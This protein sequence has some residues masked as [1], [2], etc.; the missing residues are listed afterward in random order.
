M[1]ILLRQTNPPETFT[2]VANKA[3]PLTNI[4]LDNNFVELLNVING[5]ISSQS[6]LFAF[7]TL[8]ENYFAYIDDDR[9]IGFYSTDTYN[10]VRKSIHNLRLTRADGLLYDGSEIVNKSFLI[11]EGYLKSTG[12]FVNGPLFSLDNFQI[13]KK[14]NAGIEY[15]CYAKINY[16]S[17]NDIYG[18][19][20]SLVGYT[21][22]V[23]GEDQKLGIF[24][25]ND[26]I[27]VVSNGTIIERNSLIASKQLRISVGTEVLYEGSVTS[28]PS[29]SESLSKYVGEWLLLEICEDF[30]ELPTESFPE[31]IMGY[32]GGNLLNFTDD[33]LSWSGS[34]KATTYRGVNSTWIA[35]DSTGFTASAGDNWVGNATLSLRSADYSIYPSSFELITRNNE[36][37]YTLRGTVDGLLTWTGN[38]FQLKSKENHYLNGTHSGNQ[39]HGVVHIIDDRFNLSSI[40]SNTDY[41]NRI[42]SIVDSQGSRWGLIETFIDNTGRFGLNLSVSKTEALNSFLGLQIRSDGFLTWPGTLSVPQINSAI[43]ELKP[44]SS[45]TNGG[46][47]DFHYAGST[48]D[49]T[50]RIIESSSGTINFPKNVSI[51]GTLTVVTPANTDNSTKTATTAFVRNITTT[52]PSAYSRI[53]LSSKTSI[54]ET[55]W[56]GATKVTPTYNCWVWLY[57]TGAI[58][59]TGTRA[60]SLSIGGVEVS[61]NAEYGNGRNFGISP[62]YCPAN[63][64]ISYNSVQC[65]NVYLYAVKAY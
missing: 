49:Y 39:N 31:F 47:I 24:E 59:A 34:F 20:P 18:A 1:T 26:N 7:S 12:V 43:L 37:V 11:E 64:E 50:S 30:D 22:N 63:T 58:S 53:T 5:K 41:W 65:T 57:T 8:T 21:I 2:G 46:Y 28:V 6:D 15:A 27:V 32:A 40:P 48:A 19:V 9:G 29:F 54:T 60:I 13:T 10:G 61:T 17:S 52:K 16:N 23:R 33:Y 42:L 38:E 36:S 56:V 25:Q 55:G 51:S 45:T 3:A 14:L 35:G 44:S 62:V 4:E